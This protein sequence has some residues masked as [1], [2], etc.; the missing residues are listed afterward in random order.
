[1][2]VSRSKNY[3]DSPSLP[4]SSPRLSFVLRC[5]S[6]LH[7]AAVAPARLVASIA[8]PQTQ[9]DAARCGRHRVAQLSVRSFLFPSCGGAGKFS[10]VRSGAVIWAVAGFD[11]RSLSQCFGFGGGGPF[12]PILNPDDRSARV[13][14]NR[15]LRGGGQAAV[16]GPRRPISQ[17]CHQA[18][19]PR[20]VPSLQVGLLPCPRVA[21]GSAPLGETAKHLQQRRPARKCCRN[22]PRT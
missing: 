4:C 12:G 11:S 1:M 21:A 13:L 8:Y 14:V 16:V 18:R 6:T 19:W 10:R 2:E 15:P 7:L 17:L 22:L 9:R 5:A 3:G 20:C